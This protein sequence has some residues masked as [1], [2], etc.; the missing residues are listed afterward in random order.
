MATRIF[1]DGTVFLAIPKATALE[2]YTRANVY[3][4]YGECYALAEYADA[5]LC[6]NGDVGLEVGLVKDIVK[7]Y[8]N[9]KNNDIRTIFQPCG[10]NARGAD[11]LRQTPLCG[12][13][14][15]ETS[16]GKN[17]RQRD[18]AAGSPRSKRLYG[19][20]AKP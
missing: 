7:Q 16:H 1:R 9:I 13:T 19:R 5:I 12:T 8:E 11:T 20:R 18:C 2:L 15:R 10:E 17:N 4:L 6:H 14:G 3:L